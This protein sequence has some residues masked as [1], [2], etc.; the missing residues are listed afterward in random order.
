M[1]KMRLSLSVDIFTGKKTIFTKKKSDSFSLKNL[2]GKNGQN[3]Y[4]AIL[5]KKKMAWTTKPMT[6]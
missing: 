1:R 2:G 3:P 5:R 4:Q 6:I